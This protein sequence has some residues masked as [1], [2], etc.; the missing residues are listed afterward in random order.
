MEER[1]YW[2]AWLQVNGVGP[3][4]LRR[5][6]RH[7]GN[8][9]VAWEASP[10]ELGQV[11]GLGDIK[12]ESIVRERANLNPE[13]LYRQHGD[14]NPQFWTPVDP[15]Y[16]RLLLETP[17][18]PPILYYQGNVEP[19]ENTGVI[20]SVAIVGT[21]HPTEYG[22]RWTRR[23]SAVL[24][25]RG[26]TIVSGMAA[27]IDSEAHRA[28]LE[29]GG[30]TVAVLGTGVDVVYP[31]RNRSL[32]DRILEC[33]LVLSEYPR[34]TKPDRTHFPQRN[35]IVA[36]LSRATIVTEAPTKSGALITA[37][38]ANDFGR[39]IYALPGSLDNENALGCLG[40]LSRGA[41]V[42]LGE[43]QLLEMLGELPSVDTAK[44]AKS[45]PS[46]P[47]TVPNA[48]PS[49]TI[50]LE[51]ELDRVLQAVPREPTIFDAIVQTAQ[52]D[53]GTISGA[54]IQLELLGLVSQQPGMR[55]QRIG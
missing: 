54:L 27:G 19:Q 37:Y 46:H 33:G 14:K 49:P 24:A 11:E 9:G 52:M 43:G 22:R 30:R 2:V 32:Y 39:D 12:I 38:I 18:P 23:L 5:L 41:Q 28:C 45:P 25:Q 35:R 48:T 36:G 51:P 13:R 4:L 40:L 34:G 7:F 47:S 21:R 6:D 17:S 42:I 29:V 55:Y 50:D 26:L 10:A 44:S 8:L 3:I 53:A 16:P 31:A 1:A 15:E 20:P